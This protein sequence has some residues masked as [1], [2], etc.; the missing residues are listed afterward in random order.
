MDLLP[1]SQVEMHELW[2]GKQ[3]DPDIENDVDNCVR[4]SK[5]I[6]VHALPC[7]FTRPACPGVRDGNALNRNPEGKSRNVKSADRHA[8]DDESSEDL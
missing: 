4:P 5:G 6:E 2:D 8:A 7:R 3:D 1:T